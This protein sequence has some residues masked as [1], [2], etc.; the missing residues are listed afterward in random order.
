MTATDVWRKTGIS[1]TRPKAHSKPAES[2]KSGSGKTLPEMLHK[3]H[4]PCRSSN[5]GLQKQ[6][7]CSGIEICKMKEGWH[8]C[9]SFEKVSRWRVGSAKVAGTPEN[10]ALEERFRTFS[11]FPS[12]IRKTMFSQFQGRIPV[13][14][15]HS[16]CR[17]RKSFLCSAN[18]LISSDSSK[19]H[20][21]R[22]RSLEPDVREYNRSGKFKPIP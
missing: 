22:T 18:S 17:P 21:K 8:S 9:N 3:N 14:P 12:E 11:V 5:E 1:A 20:W 19:S 2:T 4:H 13:L 16:V 6:T 7:S 15:N 10:T